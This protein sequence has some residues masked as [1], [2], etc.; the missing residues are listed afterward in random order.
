MD[1]KE[2][3]V[4]KMTRSL[5]ALAAVVSLAGAVCFAQSGGE[6]TYKAKCTMCHGA[7]GT[8]SAGMAKNMGIKAASDPAIK[9]L[10]VAEISAVVK[11]GKGKMHP[12]PG[13]TDAQIKDV[14]T[15][16]KSLK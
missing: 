5:L 11:N 2:I 9:A 1:S 7:T 12:V 14:A 3:L 10:T 6:A 15:F 16:Y 4:T 13:L 8:P